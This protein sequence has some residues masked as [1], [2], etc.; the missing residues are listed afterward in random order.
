MTQSHTDRPMS[1]LERLLGDRL[2][3]Q[4]HALLVMLLLSV[5]G[6]Y[7]FFTLF[8]VWAISHLGISGATVGLGLSIAGVCATV[9][10]PLAGW[11]SDR[12]GRGLT[13]AAFALVPLSST[14]LVAILLVVVEPRRQRTQ[15]H[16]GDRAG[17]V[18]RVP[19]SHAATAGRS[20]E[21]SS[22]VSEL[23]SRW[24]PTPAS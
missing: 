8:P 6:Q 7:T 13:G 15:R 19:A 16:R 2:D 12:M 1:A 20:P 5:T 18:A 3:R 21:R 17:R 9:T 23:T 10:A 14:V 11:L 24:V 4:T 22:S